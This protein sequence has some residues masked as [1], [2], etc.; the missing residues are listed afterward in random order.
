MSPRV[1]RGAAFGLLTLGAV[2]CLWLWNFVPAKTLLL[3]GERWQAQILIMGVLAVI[4]TIPV[5]LWLKDLSPTLRLGVVERKR[6]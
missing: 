6:E 3:F 5:L 1:S 4:L 2:A